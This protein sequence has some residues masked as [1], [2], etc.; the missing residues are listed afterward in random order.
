[1][2]RNEE[3]IW[4]NRYKIRCWI[5]ASIF[6]L[7]FINFQKLA[8]IFQ[9]LANTNFIMKEGVTECHFKLAVRTGHY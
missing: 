5:L 8:G 6:F 9:I 7:Y 1:M 3:N 2:E 4:G